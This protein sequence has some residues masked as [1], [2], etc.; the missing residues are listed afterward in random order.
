LSLP[1][2]VTVA[3]YGNGTAGTDTLGLWSPASI[4]LMPNNDFYV[5]ESSNNRV[6]RFS[7]GSRVGQILAGNGT[8]GASLTQFNYPEGIYVDTLTKGFFVAEYGNSRVQFWGANAT[9][10][11]TIVN[12][13]SSPSLS[14][15][16]GIR[17]DVQGNI[18]VSDTGH[19]RVV[20]WPRNATTGIVVAGNGTAGSGNQFLNQPFQIDLDVNGTYIYIADRY[21]HRIQRWKLPMNGSAAATTGV[22]VAGGNG[23]GSGMN[24]LNKPQGVYVS[25]KTG[26]VYIADTGNNRIQLWAVNATEGV[27]IAGGSYGTGPNGFNGPTGVAL[28]VSE[29]YLYVADQANH[30]VQRFNIT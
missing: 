7:N 11:K 1:S 27:T 12:S 6:T 13:S 15:T 25:R 22:T 21:N 29:T 9:Q 18:Y 26:N 10:G 30:R 28:D 16:S 17:L 20:C 19:H 4:Y 3:G 24:Q 14:S 23:S 5:S 2:G 8:A